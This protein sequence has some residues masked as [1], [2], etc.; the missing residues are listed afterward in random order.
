MSEERNCPN[1]GAA[2]MPGD[3]FCGECGARVQ[4]SAY[5]AA[6]AEAFD[7]AS[8]EAAREPLVQEPRLAAEPT[9]GEYIPP[10]P[11]PG[12]AEGWDVMQILTIVA[13]AGF[14]L[15]SA[16]LCCGA[17][18]ALVPTESYPTLEENLGFSAICFVPGVILGLVGVGAAYLG[19]KRR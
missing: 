3:I 1:C 13:A 8:S 15:A 7:D 10:P 14:L 9:A 2:L 11:A 18:L 17:G 19:F 5:A 6:P 4:E 16:C 12:K